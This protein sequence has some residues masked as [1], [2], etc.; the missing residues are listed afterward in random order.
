MRRIL[1]TGASG[2]IGS[3]LCRQLLRDG[4]LVTAFVRDEDPPEGCAVIRGRLEDADDVRR[5][6][7]SRTWDVVYHLGAQALVGV[8]HMDPL[9]TLKSNVAGTWNVLEGFRHMSGRAASLLVVASSDKAYGRLNGHHLEGIRQQ[10]HE[11]D[12]LAGRGIYDCSKSCADLISQAYAD[13]Y[14][15]NVR[16]ARLGNVY[17]PGDPE[18]TRIVPSIVEDLVSIRRPVIRSDGSPVRD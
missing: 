5:A 1:V 18:P 3:A 6:L 15:M 10:Y 12:P 8:G 9:T 4:E 13:E 7:L 17:G 2:F 14:G 16:I 11:T